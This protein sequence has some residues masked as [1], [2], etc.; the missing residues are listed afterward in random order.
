MKKPSPNKDELLADLI[1]FHVPE[2]YLEFFD[3]YKVHNKKD[4]W[5]FE[6]V[7]ESGEVGSDFAQRNSKN[8]PTHGF[9]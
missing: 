2:S 6:P 3:L 9:I 5:E 4:C 8:S 7:L 1:R